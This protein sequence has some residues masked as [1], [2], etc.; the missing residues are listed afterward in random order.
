VLFRS[1]KN[2]LNVTR[3]SVQQKRLSLEQDVL[4]TVSDFNIRQNLIRS[5]EE[6]LNLANMAY[7]GT[8]Q[9]FIIGK[10]DIN[11]LTLSLNRQKE[12]QKNYIAALRDYWLSYYKIR[13][14]TLFD[15][16]RRQPLSLQFDKIYGF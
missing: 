12:A 2:N 3:I 13:K 8:R 9:R 10:A 4:M 1:A 7:N 6:A 15:F 11:S 16:E 14:L 5:A